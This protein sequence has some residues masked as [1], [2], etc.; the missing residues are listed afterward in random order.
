MT[1]IP[2]SLLSLT[3]LLLHVF[4]LPVFLLSFVLIY[5][6]Q[7]MTDFLN[8]GLGTIFN[9]LMLSSILLNCS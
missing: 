5:E 3:T 9:V 1:K 7:W 2:S 6:S 4:I 8:T